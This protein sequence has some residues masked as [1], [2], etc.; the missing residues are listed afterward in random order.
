M[1]VGLI[2]GL[3]DPFLAKPDPGLPPGLPPLDM[4][5]P[6]PGQM[7]PSRYFPADDDR[8]LIYFHGGGLVSSSLDTHDGVCRRLRAGWGL[9][10]LAIDYRRAPEARWPAAHDDAEAA[11][12]AMG[13]GLD[14]APRS[15]RLYLGGD[16]AGALLAVAAA[17][18]QARAGRRPVDG[19]ALFYPL[20]SLMPRPDDP[21]PLRASKAWIRRQYL[22]EGH[23]GDP[24][25]LDPLGADPWAPP[26]L[27]ATG[28]RDPTRHEV[29][30]L[31]REAP[32][33]NITEHHEPLA[34]HG[35]LNLAG[36]SAPARQQ[37]DRTIAAL[38]AAFPP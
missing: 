11:V 31:R 8:L 26:M 35:F 14:H 23:A 6:G 29:K 20:L 13:Q 34:G 12:A 7:T 10:V 19:L 24:V 37:T 38:K 3:L 17:Q 30:R 2:R 36:V 15:R 5:V 25:D 18:R 21:A 16:S 22:P 1:L 4:L 27:I 32:G 28:G 9:N 33:L